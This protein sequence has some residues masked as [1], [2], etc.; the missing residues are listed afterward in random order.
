MRRLVGSNGAN[1]PS[2]PPSFPPSDTQ[3]S[4][5]RP[6]SL[7]PLARRPGRPPG[8]TRP[9]SVQGR[10]V[11]ALCDT[12][13]RFGGGEKRRRGAKRSRRAG[14]HGAALSQP[15][16]SIFSSSQ[17]MCGDYGFRSGVGRLYQGGDGEV[18]ASAFVLVRMRERERERGRAGTGLSSLSTHPQQLCLLSPISLPRPPPTLPRSSAPSA[19][20]PDSAR[21]PVRRPGPRPPPPSA[22]PSRTWQPK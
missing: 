9:R 11:R 18:P 5:R 7:R 12:R 1:A 4:L 16:L 19:K 13:W 21:P 17:V 14:R 15:A 20:P 8:R 6:S 2:S 3:P 10:D 22:A